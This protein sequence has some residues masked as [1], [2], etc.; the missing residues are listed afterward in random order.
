MLFWL[1]FWNVASEVLFLQLSNCLILA[2]RL[3]E[4]IYWWIDKKHPVIIIL[5]LW[6]INKSVVAICSTMLR[7][8][9]RYQLTR[10][11]WLNTGLDQSTTS[12]AQ[13]LFSGNTKQTLIY[14]SS[15]RSG[16]LPDAS[17]NECIKYAY[18]RFQI[19]INQW[20][21]VFLSW[22]WL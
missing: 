10:V 20:N 21:C 22:R 7:L 8:I 3:I 11:V 9:Q 4:F 18:Y 14:M 2:N 1:N 5:Q 12:S 19:G 17:L 15:W 16:K 13:S 6:S